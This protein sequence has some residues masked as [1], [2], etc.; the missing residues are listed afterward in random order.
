MGHDYA[1]WDTGHYISKEV[2]KAVMQGTG[3]PIKDTNLWRR[4]VNSA[5]PW[6]NAI[7]YGV[8]RG[9]SHVYEQTQMAGKD[10]W[11]TDKG[12][13]YPG[14]FK[15]FYRIAKNRLQPK[16]IGDEMNPDRWNS[17]NI[18]LR[19][20]REP[21]HK[22]HILLCPPTK[23]MLDFHQPPFAEE[24]EMEVWKTPEK[25]KAEL[26]KYTDIPIKVRNK[27]ESTPLEWDLENCYSVVTFNSNVAIKAI[28]QG[29]PAITSPYHVVNTWNA[30]DLTSI[31][32]IDLDWFEVM[33]EKLFIFL[34]WCQF[35]LNEFRDGWA[36]KIS[37][38]VQG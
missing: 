38:E 30:L 25:T 6:K 36:W 9:N 29:V 31:E 5:R 13:F 3:F 23:A 34:S 35:N 15:G 2:T 8:L 1:I 20:M 21:E 24:D 28:I 12:F 14:H 32:D 10:W 37:Q 19:K 4:E 7:G 11:N 18:K 16:Y 26:E 22:P 27:G 33:R 17:L